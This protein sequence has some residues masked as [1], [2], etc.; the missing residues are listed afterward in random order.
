MPDDATP[1][2][3]AD[4][5]AF[6]QRMQILRTR[7][8]LSRPVVA[9]L[10]GMSP[11]WVKQVETGQI[12]MPKLPVILRIAELLRVRNLSDLTGDQSTPIDLFVGPGHSRLPAVRD[13]VNALT[14]GE[15]RQ[16]PST[17]HLAARLAKA[18]AARHQAANHREVLGQL[19]P[20]LIRDAQLAVRQSDSAAD[21]R[22]AQAVLSEVYSLSQ[23]FV[24]YQPDSALLWRVAERGMV[25]AQ[26]S[27]DPHAIGLAAWLATQAHRDTGPAHFDAADSMTMEALTYMERFLPDADDRVHAIAGALQFEAAYTAACR[28]ENGAAWGWWDMARATAHRLGRGYYH[29]MTSF[30][31]AIMG[32]HAVTVAVELRAG[33]ESVRQAVAADTSSIPSRPRLARHRIEEARA[34]QLDGQAE[35]ALA[36]L[37]KAHKAAPETI[38]YNGYARRIVLEETESKIPA[39]RQRAAALADQL[40]LLAA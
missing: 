9:G 34:Y 29:P 3:Y 4:P 26:E 32:A 21:R 15:D 6:G 36:T 5:L 38:K 39:R 20:D 2:P 28:G 13:A 14:L 18:W 1:D 40:G 11:S 10:L 23:F 7:R 16:A 8:G 33:G 35:T 30:S 31:Q 12:G 22:A 27:E 17:Q 24:A 25:A 19:L 37:E